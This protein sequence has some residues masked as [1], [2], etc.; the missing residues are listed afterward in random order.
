MS[1]LDMQ[2]SGAGEPAPSEATHDRELFD[3]YRRYIES[4]NA[5]D[6]AAFASFF[7]LPVTMVHAPRYD[8]RR[9]GRPLPIVTEPGQLLGQVPEHWA[10]SEIDQVTPLTDVAGFAPHS[11][12]VG[13]GERR[14]GILANV[15]RWNTEGRP[16]QQIC[17]LYVLTRE[18]GRLGIKVLVEL[19][20]ADL[21][22]QLG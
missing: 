3:F 6:E 13:R 21:P 16:Y 7:H 19:A 20:V 9:S 15:T 1:S 17:A 4:F 14:A 11:G 18:S 22:G 10:R 2:G 8:E 5:R 12:L